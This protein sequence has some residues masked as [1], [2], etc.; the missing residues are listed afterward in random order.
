[1]DREHPLRASRGRRQLLGAHAAGCTFGELLR[2]SDRQLFNNHVAEVLVADDLLRRGY[3]VT[4]VRRADQPTPDLDVQGRGVDVAVEVYSPWE[5]QAVDAWLHEVKDMLNFADV[6]ANYRWHVATTRELSIPPDG[7]EFDPWAT[8][9]ML[10]ETRGAVIEEIRRDLDD[11]L[12]QRRPFASAYGHEGTS[13]QTRVEV[14]DV[15]EASLRGPDRFGSFSYPGFSGY[16]PAGVF[17]KVVAKTLEKAEQ[18]QATRVDAAA[19][20]LV[21]YLGRTQIAQDLVHDAHH[22]EAKAVLEAA[23]DD[24]A[25]PAWFGLDAIAFVVRALPEGMAAIFTVGDDATLTT[26]QLRALFDPIP[27]AQRAREIAE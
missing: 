6:P 15:T 21:V 25:E 14:A 8:A 3:E 13:L 1:V 22:Q 4:T 20:A 19:R 27:P 26:A 23:L 18:R 17:A 9:M 5:M 2:T 11:A 12:D 7:S 16:S 10:A 24:G